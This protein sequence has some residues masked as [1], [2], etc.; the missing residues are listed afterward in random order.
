MIHNM[1][2]TADFQQYNKHYVYMHIQ[3]TALRHRIINNNNL[4]A[5]LILDIGVRQE[6]VASTEYIAK[7]T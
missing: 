7:Y 3:N 4:S 5:L 6:F 1:L 2:S